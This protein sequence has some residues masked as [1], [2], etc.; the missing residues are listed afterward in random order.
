MISIISALDVVVQARSRF[1]AI[2]VALFLS[3]CAGSSGFRGTSVE[4]IKSPRDERDYR[5][6]VLDNGMKVLLIS[7]AGAERS[8]AAVDVA[9]GS[10]ADPEEFAGLSHF[11]EHMLF[12]G[13]QKYPASGEFQEYI[14]SRGGSFNA[15]TSYENTN[16]YFESDSNSLEPALDRFSQFFIAPLFTP[17]YVD[18]ERNAVNSEYQSGLQDDGRR[19]Q[20]VIKQVVNPHHPMAG[21]AVGSLDTLRDH[22]GVS[23]QQA[24]FDHYDRYYSANLMSVAIYGKES[25]DQLEELARR[26]FSPVQNRNRSKPVSSEPLFVAGQLP[27]Q[28]NIETIRDSRA[29][30]YQ[31]PIPDLRLRYRERP[32]DY[33]A[34]MLGHE[35]EGTLL[36]V[37]RDKGW[38]NALSA[39]GGFASDDA[40]LFAVN[41]ALTEAGV[42]HIDDIT[43][44]LFQFI[45]LVDKEG[46]N[47]WLYDELATMSELAFQ[48]QEPGGAV[49]LVTGMSQRMQFFPPQDLITAS[50]FYD[51]YDPAMIHEVLDYLT[52]E[53]LVIQLSMRGVEVDRTDP[54]Y[55]A[56]YSVRKITPER[57]AAWRQYPKDSELAMIA[58]NPFIPE[59]RDIKPFTSAPPPANVPNVEAKPQLLV[60][61]NGV[62]LWFKQD[63]EFLTPRANFFLNALT[64]VF[65]NSLH[66]SLL[67]N[68]VVNLVN[69]QLS[70]YVY[71][72]NLAGAGFGIGART[73][74]FTL[75]VGGY[76][77]KQPEL[78]ATLLTTLAEAD[79]QQE[80]F[81]IMKAE[82][83][84]GWQNATLQT[85]Y[86]RL[87][88]EIQAL[89]VNPYWTPEA[90]I[91]E[92]NTITLEEVKAFVPRMLS[93]VRLDA[94]YHGN[95]VEQDAR[96]MMELVTQYIKPSALAPVPSFGSVENLPERTR[97]VQEM[98]IP[99]DDSAIVIYFQADDTSI[100]S[101]ATLNLLSQAISS[102]FFQSLRTQQQLGY[103][104]QAGAMGILK[105]G[106]LTLTIESPV[107]D[108]LVLEQRITEF[109]GTFASM[110]AS[111]NDAQFNGMKDSL[112]SELRQLPQRLDE[113]SG[114]YWGDI[115][116]EELTRD[117]ALQMA[118]AIAALTKQQ[119]F[120][121]YRTRIADPL[122]TR[123]VARSPGRGHLATFNANRNESGAVVLEAGNT[124]Y[125][126]FKA[127]LPEFP[128]P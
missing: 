93:N 64:P 53:N 1:L 110:L 49:G 72:A 55:N 4:V 102:P 118:D 127:S 57:I 119:V 69:D 33:L 6:L 86:V 62:R 41:V 24:L 85:P 68:F 13:T 87:G 3:A 22:D 81:D 45:D 98:T 125:A 77:D 20:A 76:S 56:R 126:E 78:M 46:V 95:V 90:R 59:N 74:G 116:Q 84:R 5:A 88:G 99:H 18:R 63:N 89:L 2:A 114:R 7:E 75:S 65:E 38:A 70:A 39:G 36:K 92:V 30:T 105:V 8:A 103:V 34:N 61:E 29:L 124:D 54:W 115:L 44:L 60:N 9:V 91:A 21:F 32:V 23:L 108:P 83:I 120:D 107:A 50:Y 80:R 17:E 14:A 16:Y 10:N 82:M 100:Q 40:N 12:L 37:L 123:L 104:V 51:R 48:Y 66:N 94:L 52:P 111:L 122:S 15:A 101:R 79:F 28:V 19:G 71:P 117:S 58:P 25:L 121:Y 35:G 128:Y 43:A 112:V 97:I 47:E 113:L 42:S 109:L 106:A 27:M 73:R 96:E 31:F 26:Y 67:G 11:L